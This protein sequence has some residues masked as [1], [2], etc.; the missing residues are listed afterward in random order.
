MLRHGMLGLQHEIISAGFMVKLKGTQGHHLNGAQQG[1][2]GGIIDDSLPK[3][4]V[5][6]QRGPVLLQHL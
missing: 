5:E 1:N 3:H 2:S 4:Q 6:K